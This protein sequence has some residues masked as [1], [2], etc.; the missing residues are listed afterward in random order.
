MVVGLLHTVLLLHCSPVLRSAFEAVPCGQ[1]VAGA[2]ADVR[3]PV[4]ALVR[5]INRSRS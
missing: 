2:D 1:P 3:K 4:I 5:T